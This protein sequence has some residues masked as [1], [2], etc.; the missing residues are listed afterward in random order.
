[1]GSAL[2]GM[3]ALGKHVGSMKLH[4]YVT[5]DQEYAADQHETLGYRH[6]RG[7]Q[8]KY[9]EGPLFQS[10]K[11]RYQ[12]LADKVTDVGGESLTSAFADEVHD[13]MLDASVAAPVE[14][15]DLRLSGSIRVKEGTRNI[16][17]IDAVQRR[18]TQRELEVKDLLRHAAGGGFR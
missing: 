15:G 11:A 5:F 6:P 9:L 7:G 8:A 1:M 18:L 3:E 17:T 10:Y 12:R 2:E 13:L 14:F 16:R 4:G